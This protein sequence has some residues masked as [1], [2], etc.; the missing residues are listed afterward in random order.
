MA[1]AARSRLRPGGGAARGERG[2]VEHVV[3]HKSQMKAKAWL[4][5][6]SCLHHPGTVGA[7]HKPQI[8]EWPFPGVSLSTRTL[9][10]P[11]PPESRP[12]Q[13]TLIGSC[14]ADDACMQNCS[15]LAVLSV[16]TRQRKPR[17]ARAEALRAAYRLG[18]KVPKKE[19][20]G[21]TQ[22]RAQLTECTS[23]GYP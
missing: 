4:H 12:A 6:W 18:Q 7:S 2:G 14:P 13:P 9:V 21:H 5:L 10:D 3:S 15:I 22:P 23:P 1:R 17:C 19:A 16:Q 11:A 20:L 8:Q